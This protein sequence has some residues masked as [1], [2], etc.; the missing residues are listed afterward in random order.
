M[1]VPPHF[2]EQYP[3]Y[4]DI[5]CNKFN[6]G[7]NPLIENEKMPPPGEGY[8]PTFSKSVLKVGLPFWEETN[9]LRIDAYNL[10]HGKG[11][12]PS[13][14]E[15]NEAWSISGCR[16]EISYAVGVTPPLYQFYVVSGLEL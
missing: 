10:A 6:D 14:C 7:V 9:S 11:G 5:Y 8:V 1:D 16:Y 2:L 3:D 4:P 12:G 15:K 13:E